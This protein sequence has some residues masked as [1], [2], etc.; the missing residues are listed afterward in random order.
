MKF[1][2]LT[3]ILDAL[4]AMLIRSVGAHAAVHEE[5][6]LRG[7]STTKHQ[8]AYSKQAPRRKL[9]GGGG[10][11]KPV[12]CPTCA[13]P[14]FDQCLEAGQTCVTETPAPQPNDPCPACPVFLRC[15][16]GD[17]SSPA[18]G[19]VCGTV[20]CPADKWCCNPSCGTC[21]DPDS[22][23]AMLACIDP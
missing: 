15:D 8:D 20:V 5:H 2:I 21:V 1:A 7:S 22:Y 6:V 23:C 19:G 12:T 13:D 9:G 4:L 14:C 17:T 10:K 18:L 11:M 3:V 16:G